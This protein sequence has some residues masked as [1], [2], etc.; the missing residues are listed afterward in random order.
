MVTIDVENKTF[1][2]SKIA[3]AWTENTY[4][5]SIVSILTGGDRNKL[6]WGNLRF[7]EAVISLLSAQMFLGGVMRSIVPV[8]VIYSNPIGIKTGWFRGSHVSLVVYGFGD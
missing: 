1:G 7:A 4:S 8:K 2:K 5:V 6:Y 3:S